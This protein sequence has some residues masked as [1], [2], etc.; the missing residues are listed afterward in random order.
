MATVSLVMGILGWTVLPLLGSII[1][2]ITGHMAKSEIN[3]SGGMIGGGGM[4][5]TGLILG[6]AT[7]ILS[8]CG[9][10]TAV[11]LTTLGLIPAFWA[12]GSS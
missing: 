7:V 1:A 10:L 2:I 4:A 5:T 9:C 3:K 6:Y 12:F 11:I 8:L